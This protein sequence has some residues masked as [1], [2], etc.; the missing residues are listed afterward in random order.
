MSIVIA[1]S[2]RNLNQI[3]GGVYKSASPE[4]GLNRGSEKKLKASI[5]LNQSI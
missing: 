1:F 5:Y 4:A 3:N 2:D